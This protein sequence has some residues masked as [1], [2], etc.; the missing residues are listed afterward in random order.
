MSWQNG[1]AQN[2]V[3]LEKL[4]CIHTTGEDICHVQSLGWEQGDSDMTQSTKRPN[5]N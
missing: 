2:A 1:N 5:Y 3:G 4:P